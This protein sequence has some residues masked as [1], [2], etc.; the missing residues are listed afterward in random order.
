VCVCVC[1]S[2]CGWVCVSL[3]VYFFFLFIFL[4]FLSFSSSFLSSFFC[5]FAAHSTTTT[6]TTTPSGLDVH[7]RGGRIRPTW[8]QTGTA[9][10]RLS[11]INPNLQNIPSQSVQV[12]IDG[13]PACEVDPRLAFEADEGCLL[14]ACDWA[15]IEL[16]LLAH[17]SDDASLIRLFNNAACPDFFRALAAEWLC[18]PL[19]DVKPEDRANAKRIAYAVIYG[20]GPANLADHLGVTQDKARAFM[21]SFLRRYPSVEKFQQRTLAGCRTEGFV[22][23]IMRRRRPYPDIRS[24]N[25]QAKGHAERSAVNFA[26]QGSAA[27]IC[28]AAMVSA[29]HALAERPD[30]SARLVLQIHDELIFVVSEADIG[31][32]AQLVRQSMTAVYKLKVPLAVSIKVGKNWASLEERE[33]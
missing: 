27:D 31:D 30:L 20:I 17:L 12:A 2:G 24:Q 16:R 11:C 33:L 26:I 14:L 13:E 21:K 19:A 29:M 23:T 22:T 10:G 18:I 1:V 9:T 28:K 8:L 7:V 5:L 25:A 6:T 32:V 3:E 4:F 15:Q